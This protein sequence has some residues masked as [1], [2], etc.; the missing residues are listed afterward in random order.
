M[1]Y[2]NSQYRAKKMVWIM[3]I[4]GV[5]ENSEDE[6]LKAAVMKVWNWARVASLMV[7]K[8]AK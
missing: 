2:K 3:I 6:I 5:W 4:G 1:P 8:H 7:K